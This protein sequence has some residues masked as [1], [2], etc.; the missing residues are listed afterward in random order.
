MPRKSP[1]PARRHYYGTGAGQ[2]KRK[3]WMA[4]NLDSRAR[5]WYD[6]GR[7]TRARRPGKQGRSR[8]QALGVRGGGTHMVGTLGQMLLEAA[9]RYGDKTAL[10]ADGRNL[11]FNALEAQSN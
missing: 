6:D 1:V 5:R 11:S 10:I 9:R 4:A 2:A 3:G 7:R 8:C